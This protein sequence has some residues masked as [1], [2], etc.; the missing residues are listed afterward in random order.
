MGSAR[1]SKMFDLLASK[2]YS[3]TCMFAKQEQQRGMSDDYLQGFGHC[4][5]DGAI[6]GFSFVEIN[7]GWIVEIFT[8]IETFDIG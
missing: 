6:Y 8:P 7:G 1:L 5:K 2:G 4:Q 3:F